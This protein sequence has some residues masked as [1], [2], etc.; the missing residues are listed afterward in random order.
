MVF[1]TALHIAIQADNR[2]IFDILLNQPTLNTNL[3]TN[4]EHT[5]LYYALLKYEAG[6][7]GGDSYASRLI[8]AGV[9]TNPLYTETCNNLLQILI[10]NGTENAAVYLVEHVQNL[11]HVNINGE[12]ALH[13]ACIK[14]YAKVVEMLLKRG[15]N[16]NL[17]TNELRQ[18]PVHYAVH[19]NSVDC[20]K[21]F[22]YFNNNEESCLNGVPKIE[23][24]FNI[25]DINGDTPIILALNEDFNYLVPILI[26]GKA[27]VNVRNG[28]DFTLLHQAILKE[29]SK[30]AIFLLDHGV[31]INAK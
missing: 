20:I 17:L 12:T 18:T 10:L 9:E 6:D 23:T 11:N 30:N 19:H 26:E 2:P 28:K 14:N 27:D 8:K 5:P 22:I 16:S 21:A 29:D 1:S 13:L 4:D 15:A 31:D 7:D 3:K 24:N 25:R